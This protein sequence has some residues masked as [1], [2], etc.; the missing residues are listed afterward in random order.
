MNKGVL[1]HW[2]RSWGAR[3]KTGFGPR[4]VCDPLAT[5]AVGGARTDRCAGPVFSAFAV[6]MGELGSR[7][8]LPSDPSR[9]CLSRRPRLTLLL[10]F[11]GWC[12]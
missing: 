5:S 9:L 2:E 6:Q 12:S 1:L 11:K 10:P 4:E 7:E 8:K 3:E